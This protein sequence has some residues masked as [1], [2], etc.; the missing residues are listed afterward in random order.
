[1]QYRINKRL[2]A[3]LVGFLLLFGCMETSFAVSD[4]I[5][6]DIETYNH[7]SM[8]VWYGLSLVLALIGYVTSK[9][10]S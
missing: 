10:R 3:G 1:M 8:S 7:W 2:L 4:A 5:N 9:S 6:A